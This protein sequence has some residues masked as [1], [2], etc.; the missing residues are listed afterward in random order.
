MP[1][2]PIYV[3]VSC[4]SKKHPQSIVTFRSP[5]IAAMFCIPCDHAWAEDTSHPA[6]VNLPVTDFAD[7]RRHG[8]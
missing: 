4:P 3:P 2:A 7:L 5:T 8:E 6:L 1:L